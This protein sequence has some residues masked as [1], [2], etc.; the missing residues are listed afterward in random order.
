MHSLS[1]LGIFDYTEDTV[2]KM[3]SWSKTTTDASKRNFSLSASI[4]AGH[5]PDRTQ[6]IWDPSFHSSNNDISVRIQK[7]TF[8][9]Y[10]NKNVIQG[11]VNTGKPCVLFL[12]T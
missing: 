4:S 9:I 6:K 3:K 2:R 10:A 1:N 5:M 8:S 11:L 12:N 7:L